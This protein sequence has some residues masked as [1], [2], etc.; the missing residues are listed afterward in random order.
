MNVALWGTW[1][2]SVVVGV[3]LFLGICVG[4]WGLTRW[5]SNNIQNLI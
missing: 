1:L 3:C 4:S 5:Y 2:R